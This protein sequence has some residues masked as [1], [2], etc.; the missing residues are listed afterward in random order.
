MT[1]AM[2]MDY[3]AFTVVS[4]ASNFISSFIILS[5]LQLPQCSAFP[6]P[7][8]VLVMDNATIHHRQEILD[9]VAEFGMHTHWFCAALIAN[10][11][12]RCAH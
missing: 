2:Y 5:P 8:S 6:G 11:L 4:Y 9:L 12:Y 7:L 3:L 1:K 10:C